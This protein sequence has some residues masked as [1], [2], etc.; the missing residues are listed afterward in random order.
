MFFSGVLPFS[1]SFVLK[2]LK[3]LITCFVLPVFGLLKACASASRSASPVYSLR[4]CNIVFFIVGDM[5][6]GSC[7]YLLVVN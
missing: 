6:V 2:G 4:G 3:G 1:L 5:V 7:F